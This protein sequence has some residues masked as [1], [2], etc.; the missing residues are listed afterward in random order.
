[1]I[2][3][4]NKNYELIGSW[5]ESRVTKIP[6]VE[7]L[8]KILRSN[9][10]EDHLI[11]AQFI[12]LFFNDGTYQITDVEKK[13]NVKPSTDIDIELDN[14]INIQVYHGTTPTN[15]FIFNQDDPQTI[16]RYRESLNMKPDETL[17]SPSGGVRT[18]ED[19]NDKP[20]FKKLSQIPND[21]LGI[22]FLMTKIFE[23]NLLPE[24]CNKIPKNKCVIVFSCS[25]FNRLLQA[26]EYLN[27]DFENIEG[28]AT[29]F[30]SDA[31]QHIKEIKKIIKI[32]GFEYGGKNILPTTS[33]YFK[34]NTNF[35]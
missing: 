8:I 16:N 18:S 29:V 33:D 5:L 21:K 6:N 28:I 2:N 4:N 1:M 22:V 11:H 35:L 31:F 30:C 13:S 12:K 32:L 19:N 27:C 15:N 20:L 7:K 3:D 17:I 9:P 14:T 10:N 24:S 23:Y 34:N 26:Y 25:K